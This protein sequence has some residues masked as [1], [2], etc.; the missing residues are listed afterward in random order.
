M[1]SEKRSTNP[2]SSR[3]FGGGHYNRGRE[4]MEISIYVIGSHIGA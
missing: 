1:I 3:L 2:L 4:P